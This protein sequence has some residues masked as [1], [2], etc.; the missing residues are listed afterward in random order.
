MEKDKR[1]VPVILVVDKLLGK[2][3]DVV[4]NMALDF[5][6]S[7]GSGLNQK[8]IKQPNN[9]NYL[10]NLL[11]KI[12]LLVRVYR[13]I[14]YTGHSSPLNCNE[15]NRISLRNEIINRYKELD[16]LFDRYD[17][18][19]VLA[20]GDRSF[21]Y[22]Y[23]P[24]LRKICKERN[25]PYLIA[26]VSSSQGPDSA[27]KHRP[28]PI[29]NSEKYE[30]IKQKYPNQ[31]YSPPKSNKRYLFSGP[32]L[33][34]V[35]GEMGLLSENPWVHG[36]GQSTKILV[37]GDE[38]RD[39]YTSY[40]CNPH[41]III[42]G[43][44]FHDNLYK[45]YDKRF[46][47]K[48]QLFEKYGLDNNKKLVI[49]ALPQL[50]EHDELDWNSHWDEINSLCRTLIGINTN[51]LVSL[52]PKME[53]KEYSFIK[54]RYGIPIARELL[55]DILPAADIF[56]S[57]TSST[58]LWSVICKIPAI[59]FDFWFDGDIYRDF[60]GV[61][62]VYTKKNYGHAI[63]RLIEDEDYFN[64]MVKEQKKKSPEI[65]PFDGKCRERIVDELCK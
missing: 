57:T 47:L 33:T 53:L 44:P 48:S 23:E 42:T 34:E 62:N 43:H 15:E 49:I 26:P 24:A 38:M 14:R 45:L 56:T 11:K 40:G 37:D 51:V 21:A 5:I 4:R 3:E 58:V 8:S 59:V 18:H 60:S 10:K 6:I 63:E 17:F 36:G 29:Y 64:K 41:K 20:T 39:R 16:R 32:D 50:G 22:G 2:Y 28:E 30:H 13:L 25:I 19:S 46:E 65:S 12:H 1:A 27:V 7:D 55:A 35:L 61:V 54:G 31:V 52:H 9:V